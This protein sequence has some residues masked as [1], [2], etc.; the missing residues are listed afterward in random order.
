MRKLI[1]TCDCGQRLQVP[2]SALG[3]TGTC[4]ACGRTI[5]ILPEN[6]RRQ[7]A[8][9]QRD[10]MTL[11]ESRWQRM[12]AVSE[13]IRQLFGKAVD[14]YNQQKYAESLAI[15][16]SFAARFPGNPDIEQARAQCMEA[17]RRFRLAAPEQKKAALENAKLDEETVK[18]VVLEKLL[19]G[20]TPDVQ[21]AAAEIACRMLG[22]FDNGNHKAGSNGK[23]DE[24]VVPPPAAEVASA[25]VET[26]ESVA[27]GEKEDASANQAN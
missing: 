19:Y 1:V 13:D 20:K 15:L 25:G 3:R 11:R 12:S 17:M 6:A 24:E 7:P 22:L 26:A 27:E 2:Y 4:T 21:M 8:H 9:A 5:Q 16:D 14:L 23:G 10:A 18:R